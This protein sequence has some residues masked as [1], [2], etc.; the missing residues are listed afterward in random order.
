MAQIPVDASLNFPTSILFQKEELKS[1]KLSARE[2]DIV[3]VIELVHISY[4]ASVL[5]AS[6]PSNKTREW[7]Q[8]D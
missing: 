1:N 4:R 6:S 2:E 5:L 7:L 8:A 3:V